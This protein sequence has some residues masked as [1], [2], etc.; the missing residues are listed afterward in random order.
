MGTSYDEMAGKKKAA[1][2]GAE[3]TEIKS[4]VTDDSYMR[5]TFFQRLK[6]T[7]MPNDPRDVV[8]RYF[9]DRWLP[10]VR[11]AVCNVMIDMVDGFFSD[12]TD[13]RVGRSKRRRYDRSSLNDP[14]VGRKEAGSSGD[15]MG[16][17]EWDHIPPFNNKF[18]A[19]EVLIDIRHHLAKFDGKMSMRE[20]FQYHNKDA[21]FTTCRFGWKDVDPDD[22]RIIT[23]GG[24]W[25]IDIPKPE[26]L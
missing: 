23:Y 26:V 22:V 5:P 4:K 7:L 25:K 6:K 20:W 11:D 9:W 17:R 15:K 10:G 21:D 24:G 2:K 13:G 16:W 3:T 19:E 8:E 14:S 1:Q 18:D 12:M